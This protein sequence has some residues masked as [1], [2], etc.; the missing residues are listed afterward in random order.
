MR[1]VRYFLESTYPIWLGYLP[2]LLLKIDEGIDWELIVFSIPFVLLV[3]SPLVIP[4]MFLFFQYIYADRKWEKLKIEDGRLL[5][6]NLKKGSIRAVEVEL[7][8]RDEKKDRYFSFLTWTKYKYFRVLGSD[9]QFYYVTILNHE[10]DK[11]DQFDRLIF[12]DYPNLIKPRKSKVLEKENNREL[13]NYFLKKFENKSLEELTFIC[14][15]KLNYTEEAVSAAKE[16]ISARS[17]ET[18]ASKQ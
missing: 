11:I 1:K 16:L 8:Q 10:F 2:F 18:V 3:T 14:D 9:Q 5:S 6:L 17:D 12:R 15:N 13:I 7:F 4:P